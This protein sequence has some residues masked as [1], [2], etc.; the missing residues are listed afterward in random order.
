MKMANAH[1]S[2]LKAPKINI[3]IWKLCF[4][5]LKLFPVFGAEPKQFSNFAI[6]S[7]ARAEFRCGANRKV[8]LQGVS[9]TW[10]RSGGAG[11]D[12]CLSASPS[13]GQVK[14]KNQKNQEMPQQWDAKTREGTPQLLKRENKN[15]QGNQHFLLLGRRQAAMRGSS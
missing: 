12:F 2:L 7:K 9:R 15:T 5:T 8:S 3:F 4:Y 13:S 14:Q 1:T 11:R 6:Y 10:D